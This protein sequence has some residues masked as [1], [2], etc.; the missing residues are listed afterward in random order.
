M[1]AR[2]GH[3]PGRMASLQAGEEAC[4]I[5]DILARIE[6][7]RQTSELV[8]VIVD[9]DLH[10]ADVDQFSTFGA[11]VGECRQRGEFEVR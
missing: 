7:V 11:G 2:D 8:T 9:I 10:A 5:V 4:R 3:G 1:I 6:H